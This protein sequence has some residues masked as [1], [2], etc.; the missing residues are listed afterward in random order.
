MSVDRA[1]FKNA[2]A[3]F[4]SG[5]TIVTVAVEGTLH[6]MTAS[7]FASVSLEPPLIL[8]CLDKSSRTRELLLEVGTFA[9]NVLAAHQEEAARAFA[10]TGKKPFEELPHGFG[11]TG[12]P[13]L[14]ESLAWIECRV[15]RAIE[16]GDHDVVVGEVIACAGRS[17]DPLV[18]FDK[19][20]RSLGLD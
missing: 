11:S 13:L 9:V 20:Y 7:A 18:Y 17:G 1:E 15:E 19:S 10:Q 12:A 4:P 3:K 8:V 5:I 6:G 16:A 2:L 14:E